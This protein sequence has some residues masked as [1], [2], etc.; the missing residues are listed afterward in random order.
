MSDER[1]SRREELRRY[2][3]GLVATVG[4]TLAAFAV[5]RWAPWERAISMAVLAAL[6]AAQI[7]AQ[8]R[9]FLHIDLKRS[10]RDDLLLILFTGLIVALMIGGTLWILSDQWGRMG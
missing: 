1:Q 2:V 10:H 5:V 6:A 4:L 3:I 7:V 8:F 9:Y